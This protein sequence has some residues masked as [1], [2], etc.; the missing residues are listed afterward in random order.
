MAQAFRLKRGAV[1]GVA[2]SGVGMLAPNDASSVLLL[3]D[4]APNMPELWETGKH[5]VPVLDKNGN[6]KP[7][8]GAQ[9]A[10]AAR[11]WAE[12]HPHIE[13]VNV[14]EDSVEKRKQED[15]GYMTTAEITE[16]AARESAKIT[17]D[18]LE[19]QKFQMERDNAV[20]EALGQP[21]ITI[22]EVTQPVIEGR[23]EE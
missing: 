5:D 10:A 11:K 19:L 8:S 13:V 15:Q 12:H 18:Q 2:I 7:L 6:P 4:I 21:T 22:P 17:E 3:E 23:K 20:L 16:N 1:E 14:S 9:L